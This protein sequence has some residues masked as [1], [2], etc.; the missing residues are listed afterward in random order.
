MITFNSIF[1]SPSKEKRYG[2][3]HGQWTCDESFFQK[4]PNSMILNDPQWSPMIPNDPQWSSMIPDDPQWSP[5]I[6]NDPQWS[7]MILNDPQW[8][9]MIPN[10]PQWS[11][12]MLNDTKLSSMILN[13][14]RWSFAVN[15]ER[16]H[17]FLV[18]ASLKEYFFG[19]GIWS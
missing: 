1:F 2:I 14:P 10:D 3:K 9:P 19:I 5:M 4:Y 6:P 8:S 13:N 18:I 11:S 17:V 12:M 16:F 7:S 15:L